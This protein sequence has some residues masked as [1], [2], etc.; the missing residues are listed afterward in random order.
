MTTSLWLPQDFSLWCISSWND[1]GMKQYV[2]NATNLVRS[3]FFPGW[4]WMTSRGIWDSFKAEWC[5]IKVCLE[6]YVPYFHPV[7]TDMHNAGLW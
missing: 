7:S 6:G 2:S 1:H 5:V 4:G 3:D